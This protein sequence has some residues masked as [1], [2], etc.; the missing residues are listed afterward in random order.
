MQASR[1]LLLL[2]AALVCLLGNLS[3]PQLLAGLLRLLRPH[4]KNW[5][6]TRPWRCAFR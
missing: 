4:G 3:P 1:L 2:A 5:G 6:W